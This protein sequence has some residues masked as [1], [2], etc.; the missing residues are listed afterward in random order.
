[1]RLFVL[2]ADCGAFGMTALDITDVISGT[3][4]GDCVTGIEQVST[5]ITILSP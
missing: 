3:A 2:T 5:L 1:M 4:T